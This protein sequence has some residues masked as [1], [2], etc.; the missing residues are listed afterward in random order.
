M[1]RIGEPPVDA[2]ELVMD[3]RRD[4]VLRL[5]TPQARGAVRLD[6]AGARRLAQAVLAEMKQGRNVAA[7]HPRRKER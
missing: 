7:R 5:V 4:L 6:A 3:A 2:L 1:A